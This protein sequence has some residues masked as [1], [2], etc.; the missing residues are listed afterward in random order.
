[1]DTKITK[2]G[3]PLH[4][5]IRTLLNGYRSELGIPLDPPAPTIDSYAYDTQRQIELAKE[6]KVPCMIFTFGLPS[7]QV[8]DDLKRSGMVLVGS[9]TTVEEARAAQN[10][11]MDAVVVQGVEAGGHRTSLQ[12]PQFGD[13]GI[14]SLL[15]LVRSAVSIPAI[16]AGGVVSGKQAGLLI[17]AGA[18]AVSIGTRFL[19]S[20]E[21]STPQSHRDL[22]HAATFESK[23]VLTR[24]YTG[25]PAR[26]IPNRFY[27]EMQAV[28][29]KLPGGEQENIP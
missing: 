4:P 26:M 12:L 13:V 21:C 28:L 22:I 8:V 18:D 2:L 27:Y 16:A 7:A 1:M 23:T 24:C 14:Q 5:S 19:T 15:P 20:T 3:P 17:A 6:Y 10:A 25:R 11:G 9:A 29:A